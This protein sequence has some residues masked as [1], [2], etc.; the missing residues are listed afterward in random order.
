MSLWLR[1]GVTSF[2]DEPS[3]SVP[4]GSAVSIVVSKGH[5]PVDV[6]SVVGINRFTTDTDADRV[7]SAE[8]TLFYS[9]TVVMAGH[10]APE[11]A[12]GGPI[13]AVRD[14]EP[15]VVVAQYPAQA[16]EREVARRVEFFGLGADGAEHG[17]R[18]PHLARA[19]GGQLH[20]GRAG[21]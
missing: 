5:A 19:V 14:G 8:R 9:A 13:A 20:G 16:V 11:A 6:P 3:A 21:I 18:R 7:L 4:Q 10:V 15:T 17:V 12:R 2:C 1:A